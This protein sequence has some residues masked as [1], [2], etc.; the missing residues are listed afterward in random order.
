MEAAPFIP[1]S[2]LELLL[3]D[4]EAGRGPVGWS[5]YA[6]PL[7][8]KIISESKETLAGYHEMSEGLEH[9]LKRAIPSLPSF[10]VDVLLD[11]LKTKRY[12]RTKLQRALLAVLL[13]HRKDLLSPDRLREGV[14]YIRVLGYTEK[15]RELLKRMRKS[16]ALPVLHSAARANEPYPYLELDVQATSVYS[17]GWTSVTARD[18]FRDYYDKPV[19][20]QLMSIKGSRIDKTSVQSS[21]C[22]VQ[23]TLS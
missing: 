7:F 1:A 14:Q 13:G 22:F 9:R 4:G 8:H 23:A 16:A 6:K 20:L 2:T 19:T 15:G 18:L 12:T 17:L 11:T 5:M 10:Q 21:G 3:R